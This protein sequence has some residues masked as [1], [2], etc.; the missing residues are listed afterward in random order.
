MDDSVTMEDEI[1]WAVKRLHNHCSGGTLGMRAEH[2]KGW[3]AAARK[4]Y[5]EEAAAG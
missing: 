3:L 2:L 1:G 4:K 5:K